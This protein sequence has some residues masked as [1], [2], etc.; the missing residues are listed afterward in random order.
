MLESLFNKVA[1]HYLKET[2][3]QMF[4]CE[5]S[6]IFKYTFFTEYLWWL[7]LEEVCEGTSLLKILHWNQSQMLQKDGH[8]EK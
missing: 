4:S 6:Q 8:S 7:L 2:P 5:V 3:T 1:G